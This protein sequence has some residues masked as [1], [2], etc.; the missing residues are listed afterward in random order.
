MRGSL[1]FLLALLFAAQAQND[2][3]STFPSIWERLGLLF[4]S[5]MAVENTASAASVT[6]EISQEPAQARRKMLET[7]TPTP[8]PE[9]AT[10]SPVSVSASHSVS[11]TPQ[12]ATNSVSVTASVTAT[13]STTPSNSPPASPSPSNTPCLGTW[14]AYGE[15]T[16]ATCDTAGTQTS[17]YTPG[18]GLPTSCAATRTRKC[19]K[20]PADC[21]APSASSAESFSMQL[22]GS[23]PT[24]AA[25]DE[26]VL[27][28]RNDVADAIE[29]VEIQDIPADKVKVINNPSRRRSLQ[30]G[31]FNV[32]FVILCAD[33]A[34]CNTVATEVT[35]QAADPS[36]ELRKGETTSAVLTVS[37]TGFVPATAA[38][39]MRSA[40]G[41]LLCC[42]FCC[43]LY[44]RRRRSRQRTSKDLRAFF[45]DS[46]KSQRGLNQTGGRG[47]GTTEDDDEFD[48]DPAMKADL[49]IE[50][51]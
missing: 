42:C 6:Q 30:Q 8:A 51:Y 41:L 7:L 35:S 49:S 26:F 34:E 17:T 3:P 23:A 22:S 11:V 39:L 14:G 32:S 19:T 25:L 31:S 16:G 50:I 36:S 27:Q 48:A 38:P 44:C 45:W 10:S 1:L 2:F 13:T 15:C 5:G 40:R 46:H 12:S 24:G 37:S 28:F 43:I 33:E 18:A 4:M 20:N 47:R 29:G 9:S 21:P